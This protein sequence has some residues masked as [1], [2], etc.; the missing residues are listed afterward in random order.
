MPSFSRPSVSD[1]NPYSESLFRTLKYAPAY[2]SKPFESVE[3]ARR[4]VHGFVQWYN[5]EHRHSAIRYVTP[6]QRH[7]GEDQG[8]LKQRAAVYEAARQRTPERWSGKTRNWDPVKEV[9]LNPR[10]ENPAAKRQALKAA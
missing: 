10:K 1:D 4:W 5:N 6:C 8:L 9:W 7:R 2:P 3:A